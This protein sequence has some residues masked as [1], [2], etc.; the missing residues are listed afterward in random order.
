MGY[1]TSD[2]NEV[3]EVVRSNFIRDIVIA[4]IQSGKNGGNGSGRPS[5]GGKNKSGRFTGSGLWAGSSRGRMRCPKARG[6]TAGDDDRS[7]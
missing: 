6:S 2:G 4:D 1:M 5:I 3:V 7:K